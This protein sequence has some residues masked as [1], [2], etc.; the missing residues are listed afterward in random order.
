MQ[1]METELASVK[2]Q[3]QGAFQEQARLE[4]ALNAKTEE[5][6]KAVDA[7][8]LLRKELDKQIGKDLAIEQYTLGKFF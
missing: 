6:S 8:T 5:A 1:V 7:T 3:L 2:E 4:A